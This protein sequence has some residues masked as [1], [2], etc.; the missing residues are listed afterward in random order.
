[1]PV[2]H[3]RRI[4]LLLRQDVVERPRHLGKVGRG[5][6]TRAPFRREARREQQRI[7]LAQR[8]VKRAGEAVD[9]LAARRGTAQLEEAQMPL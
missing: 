7:V 1:V 8:Q 3:H 4:R 9:H 2:D 6:V 5:Q